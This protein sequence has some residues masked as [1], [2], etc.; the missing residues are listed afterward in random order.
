MR[1]PLSLLLLVISMIVVASCA[2]RPPATADEAVV[3]LQQQRSEFAGARSL[4][5]IQITGARSQSLRA[6]IAISSEGVMTLWALTPFGTT[7]AAARIDGDHVTFVNHLRNLYWEGTLTDLSGGH[8]LADALSYRGLPFLLVGLPPWNDHEP[9]RQEMLT[10]HLIRLV[11]G[12][13]SVVVSS[14]GIVS[15]QLQRGSEVITMSLDQPSI[16]PT[17]VVLASTLDPSQTLQ[18]EHLD[19]SFR[20]ISVEPVR[21]PAAYRRVSSWEDAI[22]G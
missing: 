3:R 20:S 11:Q 10:D 5:R 13:L 14:T 15:S 12:E 9:V 18:I 17:R 7:A 22:R 1:N 6:N 16:P 4:A 8:G 21:I 19:L 2:P